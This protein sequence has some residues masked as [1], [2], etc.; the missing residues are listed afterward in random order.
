MDRYENQETRDEVLREVRR[1]KETLAESMGS[2]IQRM[3]EDA[4]KRQT[5][6]HAQLPNIC[7]QYFPE[8]PRPWRVGNSPS[9]FR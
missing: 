6:W 8:W 1:I 5:F 2:D 4:R 9:M 7:V 3:M